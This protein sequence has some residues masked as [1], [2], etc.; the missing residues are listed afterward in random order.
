MLENIS[1]KELLFIPKLHE[2]V[3]TY[4]LADK[5]YNVFFKS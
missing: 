5:I 1:I 4:K 3:E 2:N